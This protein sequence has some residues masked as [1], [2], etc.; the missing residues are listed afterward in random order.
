MPDIAIDYDAPDLAARI[1]Q[2]SQYDL[3]H[4][5]FGV[6][7]LDAQGVILFYSDTEGRQ[8]GY[9]SKPLG[10]NFFGIARCAGKNDFHGQIMR[11]QE[12]GKVDLEFAWP[13]DYDDPT[14]EVRVR[15]QSARKGGVWMFMQRD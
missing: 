13:G 1:E 3:D 8:S 10:L 2:L 14:R 6:I 12:E 9:G 4:L 11:A 5:P 7:L 15:V